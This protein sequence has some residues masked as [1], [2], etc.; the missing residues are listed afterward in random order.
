MPGVPGGRPGSALVLA[1]WLA[2]LLGVLAMAAT[3]LAS[4][5]AGAAQVEADLARARAAAEG[6]VWAALHRLNAMPL[7]AR[8]PVFEISFPLG[9]VQVFVRASDEDGR[10]DL[11]AAQPALFAALFQSAGLS[12]PDAARLTAALRARRDAAS[13]SRDDAAPRA[14]FATTGELAA[15][16]GL[17]AGLIGVLRPLVTVHSGRSQPATE[18]APPMLAAVLDAVYER[19][20]LITGVGSGLRT[21]SAGERAGG[22]MTWRLEATGRL[23]ATE[24]RVLAVVELGPTAGLPG[25]VLE[26]QAAPPALPVFRADGALPR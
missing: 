7:E 17:P 9:G 19:E 11:N 3:R 23:G 8:P 12:E 1:L 24:G 22:R 2:L 25:R 21:P 6:G 5:G 20:A 15:L 4:S 10:L 26:W 13:R 16:P 18:A 14:A